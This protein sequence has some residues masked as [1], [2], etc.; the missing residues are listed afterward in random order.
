MQLTEA[1][2]FIGSGTYS[3][4]E[5]EDM[6]EQVIKY[7]ASDV[8]GSQTTTEQDETIVTHLGRTIL[9]ELMAGQTDGFLRICDYEIPIPTP[10]I[11]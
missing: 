8:Y 7:I 2:E 5:E 3:D 1:L 4:L 9:G 10:D 11:G 6:I